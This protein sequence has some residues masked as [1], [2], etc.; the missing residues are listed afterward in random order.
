VSGDEDY[1]ETEVADSMVLEAEKAFFASL[2]E[3]LNKV[4]QFYKSKEE[5]YM[6]RG[7]EIKF[8]LQRLMTMRKVLTLHQGYEN[9]IN[10]ILISGTIKEGLMLVSILITC[11]F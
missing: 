7:E 3:Q 10:S 4:N 5:E 9:G 11:F 6:Q 2:D 8:Q 1:Y